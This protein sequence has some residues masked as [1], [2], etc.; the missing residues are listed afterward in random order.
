MHA[1]ITQVP[2]P[3]FKR[4][5]KFCLTLTFTDHLQGWQEVVIADYWHS[6]KHV[7]NDHKVDDEASVLPLLHREEAIRE[8]WGLR[9]DT[10][11]LVFWNTPTH[12][13]KHTLRSLASCIYLIKKVWNLVFGRSYLCGYLITSN[14]SGIIGKLVLVPPP[15]ML[16]EQHTW[17]VGELPRKMCQIYLPL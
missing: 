11:C 6:Q 9:W 10:F 2:S 3:F 13:H 8:L 16:N 4:H 5:R 15:T 7:E 14:E 12:K 17:D 1:H